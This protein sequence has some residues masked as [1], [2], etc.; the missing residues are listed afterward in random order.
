M[1]ERDFWDKIDSI[2]VDSREDGRYTNDEIYEIGCEFINLTG[3]EKRSIGGWDKLLEIL[4]PVDKNGDAMKSGEELRLWIKNKRLSNGELVKNVKMLSGRTINDL[5]FDEFE[6][7]TEEIKRDLYK[8]TVKNRD[9]L[10]SYRRTLRDEARIEDIKDLIKESIGNLT[11]YEKINYDTDAYEDLDTE[12]I[13]LL[14]D[15]HIGMEINN[16][17]NKYNIEIAKKRMAEYVNKV[18]KHCRRNYVKTL[19]VM[20]LG[21]LIHGIIHVTCRIESQVDVIEQVMTAAEILADALNELQKAAPNIVYR[22]CSDNHARVI[23]DLKQHIEKENFGK[24]IDFYLKARLKNT[25]IIFAEDN[26][27]DD[28]SMFSLSNG[29]KVIGVHG[30]RENV[31][32]VVQGFLGAT[33]QFVDYVVM[34]HYHESKMKGFQGAKV[35]INGSICGSDQFAQSHRLYGSA[36]QTLLIFEN[37]TVSAHYINLD[38]K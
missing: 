7:K 8:Q 37:N 18:I 15:L 1:T 14:S 30:H 11:Q 3:S 4:K 36:E 26:L 19:N 6:E 5:T 27:D 20:N 9:T 23:A 16:F 2:D 25:N 31:N 33:K 38:I 32:T 22:S 35:F 17:Y 10:N 29:K 12:A 13:M 28:I 34:G 21:D 24:L